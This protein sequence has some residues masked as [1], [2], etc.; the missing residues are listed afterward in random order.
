[1]KTAQ[2]PLIEALSLD[3]S[4]DS[5]P[6]IHT[7]NF[8]PPS[9]QAQVVALLALRFGPQPLAQLQRIAGIDDGAVLLA[10]LRR[11]GLALHCREVPMVG[12]SGEARTCTVCTLT[13]RDAR[14]IDRWIM[15]KGREHG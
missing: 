7:R 6:S 10:D 5:T 15:A 9:S 13:P 1:M 2:L 3:C 14:C 8:V 11:L 12:D 4:K